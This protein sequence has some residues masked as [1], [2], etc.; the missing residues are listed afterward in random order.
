MTIVEKVLENNKDCNIFV[1]MDNECPSDYGFPDI[2]DLCSSVGV[3]GQ[4]E[5]LMCWTRRI[6]ND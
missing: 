3:E 4:I 6:K 1:V 2:C 5:C